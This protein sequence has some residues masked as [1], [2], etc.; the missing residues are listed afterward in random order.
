[1]S[2]GIKTMYKGFVDLEENEEMSWATEPL[3]EQVSIKVEKKV[4]LDNQSLASLV[5]KAL[6]GKR[7]LISVDY[8]ITRLRLEVRDTKIVDESELKRLGAA[9]VLKIGQNAVQAIF[10]SKAQFIAND[11]NAL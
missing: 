7:N 8:C 11:L 9:G 4:I 1:M 10:G 2:K 6:G 5:L 3:V